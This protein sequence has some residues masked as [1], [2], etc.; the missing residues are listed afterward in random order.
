MHIAFNG[1][2]WDLEHTGS[3]QYV[4]QLVRYLRKADAQLQI[5]LVMPP[6][7]PR[8]QGVPE[9]VAIYPTGERSKSSKLGKVW[10]EQWLFPRAVSALKADLAHVPYW[11]SPLSC[12]APVV[13]SVLDVI[14]VLYPLYSMGMFNRLYLSLVQT[15]AR[16][17]EQII[18]I[19]Q[20]SK[21]DIEYWLNI[22]KE[23]I[24]VTYLAPDD[25][26]HPKLG[27]EKDAVVRQKYQLPDE[28][29]LYLGG[30]D[31]RKRL[32]DL[33]DA[34]DY[35]KLA[36]DANLPIVLAGK[37]P[38]PS[39]LFPDLDAYA[40]E[41]DSQDYLQWIGYVDEADKPALYRMAKLFV[42]PSE[43]E[44]F[45]L[46]PL[47]AMACGTP[48]VAADSIINDEILES[49]AYLVDSPRT[50]AAAIIALILQKPFHEAMVNQGLA[51][52]T[53]YNW[54]KTAKATLA[55]YQHVLSKRSSH[56][57]R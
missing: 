44:G 32:T 31:K 29:I 8:P 53:K 51:H 15:A 50:M 12:S 49:A 13:V 56:K 6:H 7:N 21:L 36:S 5:S 17:A 23:R 26:Y 54:R 46:P 20:T 18:S 45:G 28:Y 19:S 35:V 57:P 30:F 27:A 2:F 1:W 43:Y 3:G 55:V 33:V 14:P 40:R 52:V 41:R 48:V 42:Y 34:Y 39:P 38:T 37:K 9:G 4:R 25:V 24:S 16:T 11:G 10:F 22:P 47:E